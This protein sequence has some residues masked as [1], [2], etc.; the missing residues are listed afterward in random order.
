MFTHQ[1]TTGL[2]MLPYTADFIE[3]KESLMFVTTSYLEAIKLL[4]LINC[5]INATRKQDLIMH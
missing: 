4:A 2:F 3:E 1:I 5:Y